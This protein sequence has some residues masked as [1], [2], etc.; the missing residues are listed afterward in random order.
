MARRFSRNNAGRAG[1]EGRRSAGGTPLGPPLGNATTP[2]ARRLPPAFRD[3]KTSVAG[4]LDFAWSPGLV[5]PGLEG[6]VESEDQV[7]ALA[8]PCLDPVGF[9]AGGWGRSALLRLAG[10]PPDQAEVT[11][12]AYCERELGCEPGLVPR[13]A[14]PVRLS[15][16]PRM[17]QEDRGK[18]LSLRRAGSYGRSTHEPTSGR[19]NRRS[20]PEGDYGDRP[21]D[22]TLVHGISLV[23]DGT[24]CRG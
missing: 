21:D 7:P 22:A 11:I 10:L 14:V 2:R 18:S 19:A 17:R 15:T 13:R 12:L 20:V 1:R 4:P 8:W 24:I 5:E 9:E 6:A 3:E 16:L 23:V